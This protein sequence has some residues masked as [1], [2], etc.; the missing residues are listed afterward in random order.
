MSF[1]E[2]YI[3]IIF[4]KVLLLK[5]SYDIYEKHKQTLMLPSK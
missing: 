2:A 5:I 4:L 3:N 1:V